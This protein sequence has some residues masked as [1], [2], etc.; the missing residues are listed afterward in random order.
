MSGNIVIATPFGQLPV[1]RDGDFTLSQSLVILK[2][3]GVKHGYSGSN[4][5]ESARI[6]EYLAAISDLLTGKCSLR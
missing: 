5:Q 2:Y 1:L 3:V 6:D 4:D